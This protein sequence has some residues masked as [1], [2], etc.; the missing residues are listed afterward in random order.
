MHLRS[1]LTSEM[2]Q[3]I[4]VLDGKT[5]QNRLKVP[6][7][8]LKR[9]KQKQKQKYCIYWKTKSTKRFFIVKISVPTNFMCLR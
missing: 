1:K 7:L 9:K 6:T 4:G 2:C 3:K 5:E 8:A